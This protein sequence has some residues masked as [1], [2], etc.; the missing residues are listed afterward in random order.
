M[1]KASVAAPQKVPGGATGWVERLAVSPRSCRANW[2]AVA[3]HGVRGLQGAAKAPCVV[4][5]G[6]RAVVRRLASRGQNASC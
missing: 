2:W 3:V 4:D 6:C 1:S 5:V